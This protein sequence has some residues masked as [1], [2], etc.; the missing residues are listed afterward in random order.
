MQWPGGAM[1]TWLPIEYAHVDGGYDDHDP[2]NCGK[3]GACQKRA[4]GTLALQGSI[5]CVNNNWH[6]FEHMEERVLATLPPECMG[7][8]V[9]RAADSKVWTNGCAGGPTELTVTADGGLQMTGSADNCW[10]LVLDSFAYEPQSSVERWGGSLL[11]AVVVATILYSMALR[12]GHER[13]DAHRAFWRNFVG[14]VRDGAA[15]AASMATANA[16]GTRANLLGNEA[17][18]VV[19]SGRPSASGVWLQAKR[20]EPTALHR[21]VATGN[22]SMLQQCLA[23]AS[24]HTID[25][26]DRCAFT[27]FHV[28]CAAGHVGCVKALMQAGCQTH[29]RNNVGLTGWELAEGLRRDDVLA[30]RPPAGSDAVGGRSEALLGGRETT[31]PPKEKPHKDKT[32]GSKRSANKAADEEKT[33]SEPVQSPPSLSGLDESNQLKSDLKSLGLSTKGSKAELRTR[34]ATAQRQAQQKPGSSV[35]L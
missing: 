16:P 8:G 30:L 26:G 22:L 29:L 28:A 15:F 17:S 21:A 14:L 13:L 4:D 32:E 10:C 35:T 5:Q 31:R 33:R 1:G 27:P 9:L 3:P 11:G 20:G 24:P 7:E 2:N 34:L 12:G 6:C 25:A 19:G 23:S 18:R